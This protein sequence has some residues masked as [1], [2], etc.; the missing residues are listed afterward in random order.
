[1]QPNSRNLRWDGDELSSEE[2]RLFVAQGCPLNWLTGAR[3]FT[4]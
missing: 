1:M 3:T 2:W 4:K